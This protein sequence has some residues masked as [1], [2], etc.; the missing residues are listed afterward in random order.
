MKKEDA[1]KTDNEE[2]KKA[3]QEAQ[4]SAEKEASKKEDEKD[5]QIK[6]LT[7]TAQR[8]QAEFENFR[9]RKER[10]QEEFTKYACSQVIEQITPILDNFELAFQHTKSKEDFIKGVELIY[11]QLVQM[12]ED[13]GVEPIN[14]Q[15]GEKFNAFEHEALLAEKSDKEENSIL[16]VMQKGYRV[17]GKVL[18]HAKV[19][20]AKK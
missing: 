20:V 5:A 3:I 12:L 2:L 14:P 10:E 17:N 11:S 18:R 8:L 16:E 19:K 7:E 4:K 6:D 9:K 1:K 15:P 13:N